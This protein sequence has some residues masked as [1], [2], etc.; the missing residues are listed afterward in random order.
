VAPIH[1]YQGSSC[2][3]VHQGVVKDEVRVLQGQAWCGSYL[4]GVTG[5]AHP[6]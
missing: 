6:T 2:R 3:C 1:D 4:E 5:G